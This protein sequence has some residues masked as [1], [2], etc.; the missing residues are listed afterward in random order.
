MA[1]SR[2]LSCLLLSLAA[3][4]RAADCMDGVCQAPTPRKG[5]AYLQVRQTV[6]SA[7]QAAMS[8]DATKGYKVKVTPQSVMTCEK[9]DPV[10]QTQSM[11]RQKY[12]AIV[13]KFKKE[14]NLVTSD[15][16]ATTRNTRLAHFGG[17]VLRM[18]GHDF[19][20]FEDGV[21]GS[22]AC[23]DM[24]ESSNAGLYAC[25]NE[26]HEE[27]GDSELSMY[28]IYQDVC[29]VVSLADFVVISAQAVMIYMS[30]DEHRQ[31]LGKALK[32]N[33]KFGRVTRDADCVMTASLPNPDNSCND[34]ERVF[35]NNMG[36][37]WRAATALMAVHS[38]GAASVNNSGFD[39]FWDTLEHS[40]TFNNHYFV[41]LLATSWCP[42]QVEATG[43]WQ[44]RRCE[45][46]EEDQSDD[47]KNQMMLNTDMCLAYTGPDGT[48][49]LSALETPCCGWVHSGQ[50]DYPMGDVIRNNDNLEYCAQPCPAN[51]EAGTNGKCHGNADETRICCA[52]DPK[53][54]RGAS[55]AMD[56]G[57]PGLG[58]RPAN[59]QRGGKGEHT[60]SNVAVLDFASH[61][62]MWLEAFVEAWLKA[63]ENGA[64]G[65]T[66][67]QK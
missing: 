41:N 16:D 59:H 7:R 23:T 15:Q 52:G 19:M 17:C 57:S 35:V 46:V 65:L 30:D 64:S 44:W 22:D 45:Q 42:E 51:A 37:T 43:K 10:M 25:L 2:A 49:V 28:R 32:N 1:L 27:Y 13:D 31:A 39:G 48:S 4:A 33:F 12:Q 21:G 50:E 55:G 18:C 24:E 67:L 29:D 6:E 54:E 34:V 8:S 38:I 61:A 11:T 66:L 36:L 58:G 14:M 26:G 53:F 47:V 62:D 60:E 63:T 56:C 20:D 9:A 3:R 40:A 5:S